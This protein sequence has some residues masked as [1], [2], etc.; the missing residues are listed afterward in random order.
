VGVLIIGLV[1]GLLGAVVLAIMLDGAGVPADPDDDIGVADRD[2]D[3]DRA[4]QG[5]IRP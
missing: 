2:R 4:G 5:A 3:R 1:I